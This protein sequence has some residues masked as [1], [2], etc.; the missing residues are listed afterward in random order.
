MYAVGSFPI[1]YMS[2][3][4]VQK[5]KENFCKQTIPVK[6]ISSSSHYIRLFIKNTKNA[7]V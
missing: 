5:T 2:V 4:K 7:K 6:K 1:F 3:F